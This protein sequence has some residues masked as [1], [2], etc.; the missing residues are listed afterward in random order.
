LNIITLVRS[1]AFLAAVAAT[2]FSG[3]E[4]AE[5]P[6][7][8]ERVEP[9]ADHVIVVSVDGLRPDALGSHMREMARRGI[10]FPNARTVVPSV[11]LPSHTSMLTGLDIARHGVTFNGYMPGSVRFET[12]LGAAR[13]AG[14]RTGMFYSKAKLHYL[15]RPG[16]VDVEYG[17]ALTGDPGT[18]AADLA[19]VFAIEWAARPFGL[20]FL[21]FREP[22]QAGHTY[23]WMSRPY[24]EAVAE[25]DE[26]LRR[27]EEAIRASG[28]AE[29]TV[30]I[31]T[32]D[33]GGSGTGHGGDT[34][35]HVTIP[36][37]CVGP[38]AGSGRVIWRPIRTFDT[39]ATALLFLG[40]RAVNLDGQPVREIFSTPLPAAAAP[41]GSE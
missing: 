32:S 22:D 17:P 3:S 12:A 16:S 21:H 30:V 40:L 25:V 24:H 15:A 7:L 20:A 23:E 41:R 18:A 28:R 2:L 11:T 1:F 14:F 8:I 33:H 19:R 38:G 9:S 6:I 10:F 31:V 27:M 36:W 29:R 13:E 37:V 4:P 35:E 34:P 39:A 5:R 26:A